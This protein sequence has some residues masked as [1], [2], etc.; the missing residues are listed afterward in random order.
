MRYLHR[1]NLKRVRV[2]STHI[3][4]YEH[5]VG[6]YTL[7]TDGYEKEPVI[8]LRNEKYIHSEQ[9]IKIKPIQKS[10]NEHI[11]LEW[12]WLKRESIIWGMEM[13]NLSR[14]QPQR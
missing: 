14:I 6:G 11:T 8:N 9:N 7:R 1:E 10:K 2:I 12:I 5:K 3:R 4:D 13:R